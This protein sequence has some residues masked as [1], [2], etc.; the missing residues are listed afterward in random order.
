MISDLNFPV[1]ITGVET[2]RESDGLALS[3]RN[4]YLDADA[5]SH[6]SVLRQ[7]LLAAKSAFV[8]NGFPPLSRAWEGIC[9]RRRGLSTLICR[10]ER[11]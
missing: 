1:R 8:P 2:V 11:N 6:A 5:R 3:S 4:R 9:W 10:G 7:A